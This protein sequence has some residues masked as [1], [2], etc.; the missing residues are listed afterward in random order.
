MID[1]I[2]ARLVGALGS[3][4]VK[5]LHRACVGVIGAGLLG[6]QLLHHLAMLQIKT[7]LIDPGKV[8][9]ANLGNQLLP[10]ATLGE[11][12]ARV[13]SEQM[14]SLNPSAPV[15]AIQRTDST[16]VRQ[17]APWPT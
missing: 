1:A 3:D 5:Q 11:P 10:A 17:L 12:K 15:R 13:R 4:R 16:K 14:K 9:A 7:L 8:D 2:S 6:G